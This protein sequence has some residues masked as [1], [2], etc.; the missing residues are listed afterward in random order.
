MMRRKVSPTNSLHLLIKN[1]MAETGGEPDWA[2]L[3][4]TCILGSSCNKLEHEE[5]EK[6]R[7]NGA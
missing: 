6:T 1:D 2:A 4:T 5:T 7:V 3:T